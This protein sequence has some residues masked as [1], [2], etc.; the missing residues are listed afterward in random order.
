MVLQG[1]R[2][3]YAKDPWTPYCRKKEKKSTRRIFKFELLPTCTDLL[4]ARLSLSLETHLPT[5]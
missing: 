1:K 3:W 5:L 2:K 4:E